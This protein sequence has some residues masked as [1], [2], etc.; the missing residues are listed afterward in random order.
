MRYRFFF[1][2]G[3]VVVLLVT[4]AWYFSS[5]F[6]Y[7]I[8]SI[9]ITTLL[10]P[11]VN[12]VSKVQ[13]LGA[14]FPRSLSILISF[15][16]LIVV[17]SSFLL[18]FIPLISDQIEVISGLN[19]DQ[20]YG[21][22]SQPISS[23]ESILIEYEVV[24]QK[25]GFLVDTLRKE[26]FG[27]IRNID[28]TKIINSLISATG[29][30]FIGLLAISFMT[31]FLLYENGILRR[32][33]ISLIPNKYFEVFIAAMFKT[34]KLLSNYLLGL[35]MQMVAIFSI[36]A[37][38]LSIFGIKYALTIALFAAFANLIPYLGPI[39]GASFGILVGLSTMGNFDLNQETVIYIIE[40]I[41][42]F[43]VVQVTDNVVLQPLIFS[44]SVKAHPLEI[45][46]IIFVGATIGQIP[47]MVAAIPAYTIIRVTA[48]EVYAGF[49]EYRVFQT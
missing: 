27:F 13:F 26:L 17:F 30:F 28:F 3:L 23:L 20:I 5:I 48:S 14:K 37:V 46:I 33:I 7:L 44:K 39:L 45:F 29:S 16:L 11:L 36:A 6:F 8:I 40:I 10:R 42:V 43:V 32:M 47:G 25:P 35:L 15:L 21:K 38:G 49:K 1:I 34:E 31:F 22:L 12:L 9:V 19:F 2:I 18:L 4:L 41:S 24:E